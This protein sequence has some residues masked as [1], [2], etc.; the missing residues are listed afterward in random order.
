MFFYF[1]GVFSPVDD[2]V[3]DQ[4][5][6]ERGDDVQDDVGPQAV[7]VHI[8]EIHSRKNSKYF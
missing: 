4:D 3:E 1:E 8:P 7:D 5:N 6:T 2:S